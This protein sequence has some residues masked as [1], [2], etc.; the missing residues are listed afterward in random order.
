MCDHLTDVTL[1]LIED[2]ALVDNSTPAAIDNMVATARGYKDMISYICETHKSTGFPVHDRTFVYELRSLA[3]VD[4]LM[5]KH[6]ATGRCKLSAGEI[7]ILMQFPAKVQS[8]MFFAR[9][10][11]IK[12]MKYNKTPSLAA[13]LW[14][15]R[16]SRHQQ[17]QDFPLLPSLVPAC[18]QFLRRRRR[19]V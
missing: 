5:N 18:I 13:L 11:G 8:L 12:D 3:T 16:H 9:S 19:S 14:E 17:K 6:M 2:E 4:S 10:D 7:S 15:R 1:G